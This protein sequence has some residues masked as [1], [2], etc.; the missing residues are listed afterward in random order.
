M[1]PHTLYEVFIMT[2]DELST[3]FLRLKK[4]SP[5][6]DIVG[7]SLY[8]SANI[9]ENKRKNFCRNLFHLTSYFAIYWLVY[10]NSFN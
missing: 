5:W 2:F 9:T 10:K 6:A 7:E 4:G 8:C 1:Q 3:I